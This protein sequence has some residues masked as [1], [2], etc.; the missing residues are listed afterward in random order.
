MGLFSVQWKQV[1]F[2]CEDSER[3]KAALVAIVK[4]F[5]VRI[6]QPESDKLSEEARCGFRVLASIIAKQIIQA[7]VDETRQEPRKMGEPCEKSM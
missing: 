4:N 5:K 1:P 2:V 6:T 3:E 7:Q